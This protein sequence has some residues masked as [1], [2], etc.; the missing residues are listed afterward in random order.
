VKITKSVADKVLHLG[1]AVWT[2]L[3]PLL[4][5]QHVISTNLALDIGVGVAAALGAYHGG[6]AVQRTS[7]RPEVGDLP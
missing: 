5:E 1:V 3:S 6:A 7:A 4:V 2:A